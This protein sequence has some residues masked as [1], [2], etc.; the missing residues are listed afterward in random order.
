MTLRMAEINNNERF[1]VGVHYEPSGVDPHIG[2]S[3][4]ALQMTNGVFDTLVN[5]TA[6]GDYLP[7]LAKSFEVSANECVYTFQLRKDVSF[8]D[9]SPFDA[10]ALKFSLDRAWEPLN[11]SQLA[12]SMLGP[13]DG[14]RVVDNHTAEI[15]LSRPYGLL[16]DALSQ[17]WL[18]P[19]SVRAVR[20]YGSGFARHPVGTGPFL[21]EEWTAGERITLK[22][23]PHYGWAPPMVQNQGAAY[24]KE[25][26]FVF[27][28]N[29]AERTAALRAGEVDAVFYIPPIDI[30]ELRADP[31][32]RVEICPVRGIPVCMMMNTARYPTND[33]SVR[34]AV[35]YAIDQDALVEEV[36][37]GEFARAYGPVS[38][39][40]LGYE[41]SMES[42]YPY[43]V[44]AA[45]RLLQEAG[46]EQINGD[47]IRMKEGE[48]LTLDFYALPVNFYPEFGEIVTRQL[49]TVGIQIEMKLVEPVEWIKAGMRGDHHLIPQGKYA[50]SAQLLSFVYH[51]RHSDAKSYG[52]S[53]RSAEHYPGLDELLED[54]EQTLRKEE[55]VPLYKKVQKIVMEEALVVPLHCNTNTFACRAEIH[56]I[57]FD[58]IG[59]YPYFHDTVISDEHNS[60]A[61]A[62]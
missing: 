9:G 3:E 47:G 15:H 44:V 7:G 62:Q 27:L 40:T 6:D 21:F 37:K 53:K 33:V 46:W 31:A 13:Y 14:T 54:A 61:G 20:Q 23:N 41:K 5:K 36:F 1:V 25:I 50:S 10:A 8:H 11:Q 4:L 38:Q 58:A 29:D 19:V 39:F 28:P 45:R 35:N 56:H 59:A 43:D 24:L 55:F 60:R 48:R 34:Q 22:R 30:T 17:A 51:S 32:F 12:G 18:A 2:S 26:S 52:W 57:Q 42:L 49:R 16:L